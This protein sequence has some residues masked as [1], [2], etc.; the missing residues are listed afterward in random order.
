MVLQAFEVTLSFSASMLVEKDWSEERE[1]YGGG[2][3]FYFIEVRCK[4]TVIAYI[5]VVYTR[6]SNPDNFIGIKY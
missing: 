5:P 4:A 1:G 6:V 3:A 2:E